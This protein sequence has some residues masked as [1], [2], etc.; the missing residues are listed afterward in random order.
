MARI[1]YI[2][3]LIA[4][5]CFYPLYEDDLSFLTLL[6]LLILPVIM[7]F[8]LIISCAF[9]KYRINRETVTVYKNNSAEIQ[10]EICNRSV[11]PL[12][13]AKIKVR[14]HFLPSGETGYFTAS[15]PVPALRTQTVT[16]NVEAA[17]CGETEVY[18]EYIKIY[19]LLR[20]FSFKTG[21]GKMNGRVYIV[22]KIS[23]KHR[24]TAQSLRMSAV[25]ETANDDPFVNMHSTGPGDVSGFREFAPGDRLSLIHHKL[26]ARFDTDM[27]KIMSP[28][29]GTRY[30]LT[31]DLSADELCDD[32]DM[33][34][35]ILER[36]MSC[37]YYLTGWNAEVYAAVPDEAPCEGEK[38]SSGK[39]VRYDG[40]TSYFDIAR[41]LAGSVYGGAEEQAGYIRCDMGVSLKED[42]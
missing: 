28:Q 2:M 20:L 42:G 22:P 37:A 29:S 41:A 4:A 24:D 32:P 26:S 12:S 10:I 11:F 30:L 35:E 17:H 40:D 39:A 6:S 38:L 25:Y 36:L 3:I 14:T 13:N 16:V 23:E 1:V 9:L 34:D 21:K 31:A 19:D 5:A 7:L 33:R 27:V 8:Q 15:V 18:V